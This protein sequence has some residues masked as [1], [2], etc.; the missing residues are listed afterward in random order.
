LQTELRIYLIAKM[1]YIDHMKQSE[2]GKELNISTMMVSRYLKKAEDEGIVTV[3]IRSQNH[4]NWEKGSRIKRK[5]PSLKEAL[6][7]DVEEEDD[8]RK[9][10]GLV[11][12]KYLQDVLE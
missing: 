8:A 6:V 3:S 1:Y 11:A 5:Y 2:I 10:V 7:V 12:A 9:S 4:I